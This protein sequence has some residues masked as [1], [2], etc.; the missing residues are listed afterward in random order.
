MQISDSV[1]YV[2]GGAGAETSAHEHPVGE[3]TFGASG[4]LGLRSRLLGT[5]GLDAAASLDMPYTT[6]TVPLS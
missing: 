3:V 2:D 1:M 4:A 6:G 5:S